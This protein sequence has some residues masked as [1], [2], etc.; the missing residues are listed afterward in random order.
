MLGLRWLLGIVAA[1][2]VCGWLALGSLAGGFRRSFGASESPIWL[3]GLPVLAG[4][5]V[6]ASLLWPDRSPL[7]HA[8][9]VVMLGLVVGSV[10]LARETLFVASLGVLYSAAWLYFYVRTVKG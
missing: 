3:T 10:I 9:A 8:V 7:M 5:L 4:A 2:I 1:A 6:I